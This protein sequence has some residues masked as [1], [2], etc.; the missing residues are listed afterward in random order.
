MSNLEQYLNGPEIANEPMPLREVHA[1]RLKI[2]AE[3]KDLT[4]TERKTYYTAGLAE[5]CR[6]YNIK[7]IP[8]AK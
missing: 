8:S 3:T 7:I 5:I 6:K 4:P 1:I 2:Y